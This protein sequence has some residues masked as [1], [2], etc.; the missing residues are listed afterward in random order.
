MR[1]GLFVATII[2]PLLMCAPARAEDSCAAISEIIADVEQ[3]GFTG[4]YAQGTYIYPGRVPEDCAVAMADALAEYRGRISGALV[5]PAHTR[6]RHYLFWEEAQWAAKAELY[7]R[8]A[9]LTRQAMAEQHNQPDAYFAAIVAFLERDRAAYDAAHLQLTRGVQA[10]YYSRNTEIASNVGDALI[11][12]SEALGL[13][14]D[15]PFSE[16][17]SLVCSGP[18]IDRLSQERQG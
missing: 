10:R 11:A 9:P 14:W 7:G 13:C 4:A 12:G 15:R 3:A 5:G 2:V 17:F 1:I 6:Y 18:V 16:A 8:A